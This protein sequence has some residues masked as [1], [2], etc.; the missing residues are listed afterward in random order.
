MHVTECAS[1]Q[2]V[3]GNLCHITNVLFPILILLSLIFSLYLSY[4]WI[5]YQWDKLQIAVAL[6]DLMTHLV[7]HRIET[8]GCD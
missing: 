6:L 2:T 5:C 7:L 3:D 4:V 1:V 8:Q